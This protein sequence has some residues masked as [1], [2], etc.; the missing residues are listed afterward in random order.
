MT[1][2]KS[3]DCS[4]AAWMFDYSDHG[5]YSEY[6]RVDLDATLIGNDQ[7]NSVMVPAGYQVDLYQH[8]NLGGVH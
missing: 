2:F 3:N 1:I 6:S 8:Q 5:G 7:G 4:S